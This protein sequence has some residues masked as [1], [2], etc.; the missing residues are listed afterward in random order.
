MIE[1]TT[2]TPSLQKW[3]ADYIWDRTGIRRAKR[4]LERV[5]AKCDHKKAAIGA[6][7]PCGKIPLEVL[8]EVGYERSLARDRVNVLKARKSLEQASRRILIPNQTEQRGWYQETDCG[9]AL[10]PVGRIELKQMLESENRQARARRLKVSRDIALVL[11][12]IAA[13]VTA[14][15][16]FTD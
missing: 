7:Y 2:P 10:T 16:Q 5:A 3:L 8:A 6:N 15:L 13:I 11:G 1:G 4:D 9:L 14:I 12:A